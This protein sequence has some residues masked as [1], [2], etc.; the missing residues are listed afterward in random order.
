MRLIAIHA[1]AFSAGIALAISLAWPTP[2]SASCIYPAGVAK[3][4]CQIEESQ[5]HILALE[6]KLSILV[7][8]VQEQART[9]RDLQSDIDLVR[10]QANY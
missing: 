4:A 9:I 5:R 2:A 10:M 7:D 8:Q 1:L 3:T 6:R